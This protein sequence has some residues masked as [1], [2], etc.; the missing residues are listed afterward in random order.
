LETTTKFSPRHE[1]TVYVYKGSVWVVAGNSWPL[2]NDVWRLTPLRPAD[3][4]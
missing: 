3:L 1:P 4:R 2:M